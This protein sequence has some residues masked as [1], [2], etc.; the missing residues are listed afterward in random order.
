MN[1][2]NTETKLVG[3][4][5]YPLSHSRSAQ[6]QNHAF[7]YSGLNFLYL[8]ME[9][10]EDD[11]K[12]V[13]NGIRRMNFA[14]FNVTIPY[15][16]KIMEYIDELDDLA[17]VIGSV[18]TAVVREKCIKGYNT[19]GEGFV[20]GL[21]ETAGLSVKGKQVVVLGSGGAARAVTM[22]LAARGV[23]RLFICNRTREKADGLSREINEKIKN[24]AAVIPMETEAV[25]KALKGT[26][27]L[28]NTTSIGM[29]PNR[30]Q[31]PIDIG[32]V[33]SGT[34]VCDI[35]YNP[36]RTRLLSEASQ[37]GCVTVDGIG[38]LVNQGAEA[39]KLWTGLK[40]PVKEMYRVLANE[41]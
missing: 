15:K 5:G 18:N 10:E 8:P 26:E 9:V 34:V 19:D 16:T 41:G 33:D 2:I 36:V 31:T 11:L 17:G 39:F 12:A 35:V 1:G 28:I 6:M 32:L 22:T 27:I 24:C 40:A 25:K 20:R 23:D 38:M 3:L 14:G 4:L 7:K 29:Y 30:Q 13:V 37:K 21:A